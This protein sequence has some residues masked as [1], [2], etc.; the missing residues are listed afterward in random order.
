MAGESQSVA[1]EHPGERV[2]SGV[3]AGGHS[4]VLLGSVARARLAAGTRLIGMGGVGEEEVDRV[5]GAVEE[6][7][8]VGLGRE[9]LLLV[10]FLAEVIGLALTLRVECHD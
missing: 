6:R 3:E 9:A 10:G 7:A 8:A 1:V 4:A 5:L 2:V